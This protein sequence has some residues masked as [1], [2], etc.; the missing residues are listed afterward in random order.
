[1]STQPNIILIHTDQHR[2]DCLSINQHPVVQTPNLDHLAHAGAQF[3]SA[4]SECPTCIPARHTL[5]TGMEPQA[6]GVVGFE[7]KARI[8][9]ADSTL[10]ELLKRGG[11]QTI[12]VGRGMHQYPGHAHYGFEIVDG[13][14]FKE[15]Y[16]RFHKLSIPGG[17]HMGKVNWPHG[18]THGLSPNS[19]CARPWPH[20]EEF[21]ETNFSVNKAIEHL[22][23]RDKD[24]PL[25]MS[26]GFIAPHPPLAPPRDY[27]DRYMQMDLPEP[28]IGDWAE[29]PKNDGR[30]LSP[31]AGKQVLEGDFMR[32]AQAAYYALINHVDD[33][34]NLLFEQIDQHLDDTYI[35]FISDH[36]EMLG[37]HYFCRKALPYEASSHIPFI[38]KGPDIPE[39][40]RI[41]APV[42][43][44]DI[45]PTC[46]KI[47]GIDTPAHVTGHSI[48][49]LA[50]REDDAE[51][52]SWIHGEH[53][54]MGDQHPGVHFLTDG[55]CKFIWFNDGTEQ[56]FDLENDP[57]ECKNLINDSKYAKEVILWRKR[58]IEKLADRPER[59]SDGA[60]LTPSKNYKNANSV[61]T[62]D[63]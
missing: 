4:Y 19:M 38:L 58:L 63:A 50:R 44:Q 3:T 53:A 26:V 24:R 60:K 16:S 11:Y 51:S 30:G 12:S 42:G 21:H 35:F 31:G 1:M 41:E 37:D 43:L 39:G 17:N 13:D 62:V 33:Q 23:K 49:P 61:A 10:P 27:Y 34:L 59:F 18:T 22:Y 8:E 48:L 45:L 25:F 55:K 6:T 56:F 32:Q 7:T 40:S 47:A 29:R 5:L 52:R 54:P 57:R 28:V 20:D 15:H 46:C 14:P 2:G 9:R 36:G